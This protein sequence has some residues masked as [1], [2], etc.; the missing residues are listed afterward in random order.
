MQAFSKLAAAHERGGAVAVV[1]AILSAALRHPLDRQLDDDLPVSTAD[2]VAV[3]DLGASGPNAPFAVEYAPTPSA[4][5]DGLLADLPDPLDEFVFVDFGSGKGRVLLLAARRAFKGVVGVEF[6]P[7]LH[8]AAQANIAHRGHQNRVQSILSDATLFT[9]PDA[10][11]VFYFYNPFGEQVLRAVLDNI[12]QAYD[13]R[14]R[15]M[16]LIYLNPEHARLL[17]SYPA[18]QSVRRSRGSRLR[19]ALLSEHE[20]FI[21]Q[22]VPVR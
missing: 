17:E 12:L 2:K 7:E 14:P 22:V 15:P 18:L 19:H 13:R 16:F 11:C 5:L 3:G 1:R 9:I 21:Y 8:K 20:G 10:P 6:S 4:V